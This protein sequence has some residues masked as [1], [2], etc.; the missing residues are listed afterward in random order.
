MHAA[1]HTST[2]VET[3][4]I[5]AYYKVLD[6]I[7]SVFALEKLYL[8]PQPNETRVW[9]GIQLLCEEEVVKW[10]YRAWYGMSE[11]MVRVS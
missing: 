10:P 5:A 4:A 3:L 11:L 8:P 7:L 1:E 6:N 9:Y 2:A